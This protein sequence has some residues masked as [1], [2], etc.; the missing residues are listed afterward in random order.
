V[1]IVKRKVKKEGNNNEMGCREK[2]HSEDREGRMTQKGGTF[3]GKKKAIGM[4]GERT[5]RE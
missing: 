2:S 1:S 5:L 4:G 3:Q